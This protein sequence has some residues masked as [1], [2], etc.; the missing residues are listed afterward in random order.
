[1]EFKSKVLIKDRPINT[2]RK[3]SEDDIIVHKVHFTLDF[4][5][6]LKAKASISLVNKSY[7]TFE[8]LVAHLWRKITKARGL[9]GLEETHLRISVNGRTRMIPRVPNEYFGNLVLW[10]FPTS[11]VKDLDSEPVSYAAQL[12]HD[13]ITNVNDTYFK[14]FIDFA[15]HEVEKEDLVPTAEMNKLILW[16]NLEVDSW[17]RFPFHDMDFGEGCPYFFIPSYYPIEGMMFLLPSFIEDGSIDAFVPLF[18]DNLS[19]FK[20]IVYSLD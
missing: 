18:H 7:S 10:A 1:M 3:I 5:S 20:Q 11:R 19:I 9:G 15:T 14:S 13:A 4:L 8:S 2:D 12:I 17:M 6:K 16:P